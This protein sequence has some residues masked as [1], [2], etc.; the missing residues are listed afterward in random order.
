MAVRGVEQ[1]AKGFHRRA[2]LHAPHI[3]GYRLAV[4]PAAA[5]GATGCI[6]QAQ[7]AVCARA[8]AHIFA[9]A[10]VDSVVA[11]D[12]RGEITSALSPGVLRAQLETS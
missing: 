10:P 11:A 3:A 7:V 9:V 1:F 8:K 4:A 2:L 5:P 12:L 6:M